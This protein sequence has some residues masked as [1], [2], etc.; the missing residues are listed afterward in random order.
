MTA[1]LIE[2][3]AV[4]SPHD[5]I[6]TVFTGNSLGLRPLL[7]GYEGS[8]PGVRSKESKQTLLHLAVDGMCFLKRSAESHADVVAQL[9]R[10]GVPVDAVE[11]ARGRTCLQMYVGDVRWVTRAYENS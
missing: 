2:R 6:L 5:L 3:G 8:I 11:P 7:D 1:W 4:V 10:Q 9:L